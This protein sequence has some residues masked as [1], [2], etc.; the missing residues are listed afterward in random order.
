MNKLWENISYILISSFIIISVFLIG[1]IIVNYDENKAYNS[2]LNNSK[3]FEKSPNN[4]EN[5]KFI[6]DGSITRFTPKSYYD[7][8][9]DDPSALESKHNKQEDSESTT[10]SFQTTS[11]TINS[12]SSENTQPKINNENTQQEDS[13]STTQSFQT[14]SHTINSVS[15]VSSENTQPRT[16][17][18]SFGQR[19]FYNPNFFELIQKV[20]NFEVIDWGTIQNLHPEDLFSF[21][22]EEPNKFFTQEQRN[23]IIKSYLDDYNI[24]RLLKE[25]ILQNYINFQELFKFGFTWEQLSFYFDFINSDFPQ[26]IGEVLKGK[27]IVWKQLLEKVYAHDLFIFFDE[28]PNKFFTPEQRNLIIKSYLDDLDV[29]TTLKFYVKEDS[30]RFSKLLKFGFTWEQ[31]AFCFEFEN[32]AFYKYIKNVLKGKPVDFIDSKNLNYHDVFKFFIKEPDHFLTQQQRSRIIQAYLSDDNIKK[33]L[34]DS[35]RYDIISVAQFFEFGFTWEQLD[36]LF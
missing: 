7:F 28:E 34:K 20:L 32:K 12:V 24:R 4:Q 33:F 2:L 18:V 16:N 23:L 22:K 35:I 36:V 9:Q 1:F 6:K 3:I 27:K 30:K 21:F 31:L 26:Y 13:E 19:H 10:Q 14:T 25:Y 5:T 8:P 11:H 29:R 17:I 15:S